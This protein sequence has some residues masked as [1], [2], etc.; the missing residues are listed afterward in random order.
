MCLGHEG[1]LGAAHAF[2]DAVAEAGADAVKFQTHIASAEGTREEKFRVNVFV[3]DA[4][5]QAY[6][7]RTAFTEEQWHALKRHADERKLAFLSSPFS[8]QAVQLLSRV[9]VPAWKIGSGETSNTPLLGEIVKTGLP[10]LMSTGMSR[11]EEIDRAASIVLEK[12][13]PLVLFQCSSRYPCPPEQIGLNV[14]D[15]FRERYGVPVGYS[16]HSGSKAPG[17][18]AYVLGA[19][20]VEVHVAFSRQC[21][22]PDVTSSLTLDEFKDMAASIRVLERVLSSPVDKEKAAGDLEDVRRLFTKS[23]VTSRKMPK[24]TVLKKKDLAFK[25]PGTGIPAAEAA[26]VIGR[27]LR[28]SLD[29]DALLSWKDLHDR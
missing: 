29:K 15:V 5:R 24:G 2:I 16:D 21:F 9:G 23:I 13:I 20:A 19:C 1:S 14:I 26:E 3:Q 7:E 4:T 27:K 6:W 11:L 10:I 28:R 18:G 22:G 12:E 8:L 17:I 25:K